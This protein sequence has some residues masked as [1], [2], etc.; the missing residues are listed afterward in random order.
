MLYGTYVT[1][2]D[3]ARRGWPSPS[4]PSRRRRRGVVGVLETCRF[5]PP[6]ERSEPCSWSR[7]GAF[8]NRN[9]HRG[10]TRRGL[11]GSERDRAP[12][13]TVRGL[14]FLATL[15]GACE[16]FSKQFRSMNGRRQ[17]IH[18]PQ[19]IVEGARAARELSCSYCCG[20]GKQRCQIALCLARR[21][22][23]I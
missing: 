7:A 4:T 5:V 11:P 14:P 16:S 9:G 21:R 20:A 8:R 3:V 17:R 18:T 15:V 13:G 19:H 22:N 10:A 2:W 6:A 12:A 1:C 23:F